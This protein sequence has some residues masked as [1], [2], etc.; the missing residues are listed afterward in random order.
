MKINFLL[1]NGGLSALLPSPSFYFL[2]LSS[3]FGRFGLFVQATVIVI[4]RLGKYDRICQLVFT[5]LFRF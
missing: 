2:S 1:S 4:E 5:L 3:L